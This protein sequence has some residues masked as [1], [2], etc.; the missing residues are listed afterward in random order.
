MG[1]F[2]ERAM[3]A[4]RAAVSGKFGHTEKVEN[5]VGCEGCECEERP[6]G[7]H[8]IVAHCKHHGHLWRDPKTGKTREQMLEASGKKLAPAFASGEPVSQVIR[9]DEDADLVVLDEEIAL[10]A[11]GLAI[12]LLKLGHLAADAAKVVDDRAQEGTMLSAVQATIQ[13]AGEADLLGDKAIARAVEA[14]ARNVLGGGPATT[15]P[16]PS[17]STVTPD[18]ELAT[19]IECLG[20]WRPEGDAHLVVCPKC[21]KSSPYGECRQLYLRG[22][23]ERPDEPGPVPPQCPFIKTKQDGKGKQ[24]CKLSHPHPD[25]MHDMTEGPFA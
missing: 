1:L 18:D 14:G 9:P 2:D 7:S 17:P 13:L 11:K 25:A 16:A 10:Q 8:M 20:V 19:C 15:E 5:E 12:K 4:A 21:G 24:R 3:D 6:N 23:R 22:F